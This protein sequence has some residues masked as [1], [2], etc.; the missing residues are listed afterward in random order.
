MFPWL[1]SEQ[2]TVLSSFNAES[3][4]IVRSHHVCNF[5]GTPAMSPY[6]SSFFA[7]LVLHIP[8]GLWTWSICMA[9][10]YVHMVRSTPVAVRTMSVAVIDM[11]LA[12]NI[13]ACSLKLV[14]PYCTRSTL[15]FSCNAPYMNILTWDV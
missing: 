11:L 7:L 12:V 6:H 9:V 8:N 5:V 14:C 1:P 15:T 4:T 3:E 13:Y 10:W 2:L